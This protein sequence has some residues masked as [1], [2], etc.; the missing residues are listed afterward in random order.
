MYVTLLV[1]ESDH[2]SGQVLSTYLEQ[3][4]YHVVL[5]EG[6]KQA[7]ETLV[8]L[9]PSVIL[10][11]LD[12]A[13]EEWQEFYHWLRETSKHS[14][15][16]CLWLTSRIS[17]VFRSFSKGVYDHLLQKPLDPD[18][19]LDLLASKTG[20]DRL[21]KASLVSEEPERIELSEEPVLPT[22][23]QKPGPLGDSVVDDWVRSLQ[24]R[25][26]GSVRLEKEVGRGGMGVVFQGSQTSLHRNVAVKIMLPQ[27]TKKLATVERFQREALATAKLKSPHIVQIFEAGTT[28]DQLFFLVMEWLEGETLEERIQRDKHIAAGDALDLM[29]QTTSGL[30]V[31]HE[32]GLIHRDLKPSNLIVGS[33]GHVSITDFGL[34]Y[35]QHTPRH[36]QS[37]IVVG[38]PH[39]LSPEQASGQGID[40][41]SDIYAL[42]V[43]FFELLTGHVP[44]R[45]DNL[46]DLLIAHIQ[47]PLPDP[48]QSV[49]SV[50]ES[51]VP[52]LNKMAAKDPRKRYQS[53]SELYQSLQRLS[54]SWKSIGGPFPTNELPVTDHVVDVM[55]DWGEPEPLRNEN[56]LL[57]TQVI[58]PMIQTNQPST[59]SSGD[60]SHH[61][62]Y[63]QALSL[64]P[65][66]L[67][68]SSPHWSALQMQGM[69]L[70]DYQGTLL[71]QEGAVQ[72]HW[73]S[74]L[75]VLLGHVQQILSAAPL[76]TWEYT[77]LETSYAA[78]FL[79]PKANHQI[80]AIVRPPREQN[81][82]AQGPQSSSSVHDVG[83]TFSRVMQ[84]LHALAGV[85]NILLYDAAVQLMDARLDNQ[86][87][88]YDYPLKMSPIIHMLQAIPWEES[89][90]T[91]R[92]SDGTMRFWPINGAFLCAQTTP[93]CNQSLLSMMVQRQSSVAVKPSPSLG[94]ASPGAPSTPGSGLYPSQGMSSPG[95]SSVPG[96]GLYP[97]QYGTPAP[98]SF[99]PHV[100]GA[101]AEH[102]F[103]G[104][105]ATS[106][107]SV[108]PPY[109]G[110]P[111]SSSVAMKTLS[112]SSTGSV[113][114]V[115][116]LPANNPDDCMT[117]D[118][119]Q[120][121][122]QL[123]TKYT[124]PI[125][126]IVISKTMRKMGFS[127][128]HFPIE[129]TSQ[130]LEHL[131]ARIKGSKKENF[132]KQS[133]A[134]VLKQ[135]AHS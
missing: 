73:H 67:T 127:L 30:M 49:P 107:A 129:L 74:A 115:T 42:G 19:F 108:F 20:H 106:Q 22:L 29:I 78:L 61:G 47:K 64:A 39:Y 50:P 102:R 103:G 54:R 7:R 98:P 86:T 9:S 99:Q 6:P 118:T 69:M 93:Q 53:A 36:T 57:Q 35:N 15:T 97:S 134:L 122:T 83:V 16:P 117:P 80:L 128:E 31:A 8:E 116:P 120:Q 85:T 88:P 111:S 130:L 63:K 66:S 70:V 121:L 112:H 59:L 100:S 3:Q 113:A 105:S 81:Q 27:L 72:A 133:D 114:P 56:E 52:I 45:A 33:D 46:T 131:A 75:A 87:D 125:G 89:S 126:K 92:F 62:F 17:E 48:R 32:A 14:K 44:F 95:S 21:S 101:S 10:A 119:I 77:V 41:R 34:V 65:S 84:S 5:V 76:G 135:H 25:M 51:F 23:S 58:V 18:V 91:C 110:S 37:G 109:S 4:S 90:L 28:E 38:T 79:L 13:G 43:L 11:D 124:G 55:M 24:G 94:M 1:V 40:A 12:E 96:S 71:Q 26:I 82:P 68:P 104:V 132:L 60:L 2:E 123:L